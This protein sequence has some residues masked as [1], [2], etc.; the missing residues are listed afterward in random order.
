[1]NYGKSG[2]L[3]NKKYLPS[4]IYTLA[5]IAVSISFIPIPFITKAIQPFLGIIW[6]L[7]LLL[8]AVSSYPLIRKYL[9]ISPSKYKNV[10]EIGLSV[11]AF[12]V[13]L[14]VFHIVHAVPLALTAITTYVNPGQSYTCPSNAYIVSNDPGCE[15]TVTMSVN[16]GSSTTYVSPSQTVTC[17]SNADFQ[18]QIYFYTV[19]T[20]TAVTTT[21]TETGGNLGSDSY[22]QITYDGM[23]QTAVTGNAI[24]FTT[25]PG[26]YSFSVGQVQDSAGGILSN[27]I[28]SPSSGTLTAGSSQ[29][30]TF[31][32]QITTTTTNT[33]STSPTTGTL[34]GTFTL[35]IVNPILSL[36]SFLYIRG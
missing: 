30:I 17:P 20:P 35:V 31:T 1:M 33:N 18:C 2:K 16:S 8:I 14:A 6:I 11:L 10:E 27:E 36:E 9:H 25:A 24:L 22:W 4:V 19:N 21:F 3:L 26:T 28:A 5:V 34:S 13:L 7:A 23:T 29:L 15:W 12:L 32:E